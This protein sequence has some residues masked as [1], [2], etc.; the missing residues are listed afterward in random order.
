[1]KIKIVNFEFMGRIKQWLVESKKEESLQNG[2]FRVLVENPTP[3]EPKGDIWLYF[4]SKKYF[5]RKNTDIDFT[6]KMGIEIIEQ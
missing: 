4:D 1:M 2:G 3:F 6:N 5:D